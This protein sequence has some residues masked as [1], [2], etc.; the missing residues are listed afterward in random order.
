MRF[1]NYAP[2]IS[3]G[4]V[5]LYY[6][7]CYHDYQYNGYYYIKYH[8]RH[9]IKSLLSHTHPHI[10]THTHTHTHTNTN[11]HPH[12]PAE[13]HACLTPELDMIPFACITA[14][15]SNSRVGLVTLYLHIRISILIILD[16]PVVILT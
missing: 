11:T 2:L 3:I 7:Y 15:L 10:H 16:T 14:G 9:I 4:V 5:L 13:M 1:K 6:C 8:Y 12:L